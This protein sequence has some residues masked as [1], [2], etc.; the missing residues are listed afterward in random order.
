MKTKGMSQQI[1]ALRLSNGRAYYALFM[2]QGT[3]KTWTLLAEAERSFAAGTIDAVLVFAPKGVHTN[4]VLREIPEHLEVP[5]V[6]R[7]WRAGMGK[8]ER[9]RLED[10]FEPRG[11]GDVAP[12]RILAMNYDAVI[13]KDGL[14]MA[15][16]FLN[17]TRALMI[18]DESCTIKNHSAKRTKIILKLRSQA[19]MRRLADG[20]PITQAPLDIFSPMEFL[21]SGLLGTTS[22]RAFVAEFADVLPATHPMV[23][24]LVERN[25]NA[26]M[27]QI[28]RR[29]ENGEPVY[30]NLERL[31]ALL[32]PHSYRVLKKDCL[33][34]PDKVYT[35]VFFELTPK[36]RAAYDL[37]ENELRIL[38]EDGTIEPVTA[39]TS[40]VKL[41]QITSG[42]VNVRS[43]SDPLLVDDDNPRIDAVLTAAGTCPGKFIVWA[44]F[45]DE[46]RMICAALRKAGYETVEYHGAIGDKD[47]EAAVD[48]FQRGSARAFVGNPQA[49]GIGLTLTAAEDAIYC[50]NSFKLRDRLQSEDRCHRI[51]TKNT[52]RYTDIVAT[53]TVDEAIARSL[54]RKTSVAKQILDDRNLAFRF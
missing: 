46:I 4:W 51:G 18:L 26:A 45:V 25:P 27:A 5:Y 36:Q 53:G 9:A 48:S 54:Q 3:G 10:L 31:K 11:F 33:D 32:E 12:L 19:V 42:Y 37:M 22:Y 40:L 44:R 13:T 8:R 24:K 15:E 1:E 20:T 34:L 43:S 35:T 16:R 28:I 47:R 6:A 17:A 21:R 49:G 14:A 2:E 38:L 29:D 7:A 41:Q 52:V 50:S 39:L 23:R 30:R